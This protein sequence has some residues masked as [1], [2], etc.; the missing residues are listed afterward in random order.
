VT[1]LF[2]MCSFTL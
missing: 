1:R 2:T